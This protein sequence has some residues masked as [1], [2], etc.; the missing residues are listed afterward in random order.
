MAKGRTG[1]IET[2]IESCRSEGKW[3]KSIELAE[4][5]R[6]SSNH[7]RKFFMEKIILMKISILL[8]DLSSHFRMSIEILDRRRKTG[9]L[10]RRASTHRDK[11]P[12]SKIGFDRSEIAIGFSGGR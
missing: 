6:T 12:E 3:S 8:I 7:G 9:K 10:F 5:L 4:E 11:F 1:K 2:L